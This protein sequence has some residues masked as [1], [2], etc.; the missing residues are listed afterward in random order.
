MAKDEIKG[1]L[2]GPSFTTKAF[3]GPKESHYEEMMGKSHKTNFCL[4]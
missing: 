1:Q 2:L 3:C 4:C